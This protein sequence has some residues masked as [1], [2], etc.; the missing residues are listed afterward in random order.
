MLVQMY[1]TDAT[2]LPWLVELMVLCLLYSL[3]TVYVQIPLYSFAFAAMAFND[4]AL[5]Y[6]V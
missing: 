6:I 3:G 5:A 1:L 4:D 2:L